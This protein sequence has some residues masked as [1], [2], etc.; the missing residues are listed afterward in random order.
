MK[1]EMSSVLLEQSSRGGDSSNWRTVDSGFLFSRRA[2]EKNASPTVEDAVAISF[3][4]AVGVP[5]YKAGH[6]AL[7]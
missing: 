3:Q 4:I 6:L 7:L 1:S 5:V 2:V